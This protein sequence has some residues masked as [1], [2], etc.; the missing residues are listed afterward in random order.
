MSMPVL[1]D[2]RWSPEDLELLPSDG[3]RYECIDGALLVTPAP[4]RVHQL[5]VIGLITRMSAHCGHSTLMQA[6]ISPA[7]I[8]L[9]RGTTVQPDVFV[10]YRPDGG[11]AGDWNTIK[12][13]AVAVEILSPGSVRHDRVTKRA[14]YQRAGVDEY[15][16]VDP[17]SR[18][19]ERWRPA[20]RQPE[21]CELTIT[22]SAL[23][24]EAL[25]VIDLVSLFAEAYGER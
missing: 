6:C 23:R 25:L 9:V 12:A 19:V 17:E 10:Y 21:S 16:I 24:P 5:L 8:Q 11:L 2:R 4:N 18:C 20:D 22:W 13:L 3:N 14:F 1:L 15:W 7:D